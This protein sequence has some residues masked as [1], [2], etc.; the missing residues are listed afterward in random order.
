MLKLLGQQQYHGDKIYE[1][2]LDDEEMRLTN[3][4]FVTNW[5]VQYAV[6]PAKIA[7][8]RD[9]DELRELVVSNK[10]VRAM[11]AMHST[12]AL[13]CVDEG[14]EKSVIVNLKNLSNLLHIDHES[15]RIRCGAGMI[16]ETLNSVMFD[17]GMQLP[18][19]G[20]FDRQ[21]VGGLIMTGT[22]GGSSYHQAIHEN[23][24]WF[25]VMLADGTIKD[26]TREHDE[27]FA[28]FLPSIGVLG[29]VTALELQ[30]VRA[31]Y[32]EA[33]H[34]LLP[35]IADTEFPGGVPEAL[36][37]ASQEDLDS[38]LNNFKQGTERTSQS[39]YAV[40]GS[41]DATAISLFKR[42]QAENE[43][44]RWMAYTHINR[45]SVWV[46]NRVSVKPSQEL[47]PV[48]D[49]V[50]FRSDEEHK[51]LVRVLQLIE[52]EI[53]NEEKFPQIQQLMC[54]VVLQQDARLK[55]YVGRFHHI[56]CMERKNIVPHSD[57]EVAYDYA[58]T[59]A[60]L[61]LLAKDLQF[62]WGQLP[63][64]TH[65]ASMSETSEG[66]LLPRIPATLLDDYP[67][68]LFELRCCKQG[69]AYLSNAY[70]RDVLY[71]EFKACNKF[72]DTHNT[73]MLNIF[74]DFPCMFH[75]GKCISSNLWQRNLRNC[76]ALLDKFPEFLQL[77]ES[78]DPEGKFRNADVQ[79]WYQ[80]GRALCGER[81]SAFDRDSHTVRLCS[82]H[83]NRP[84][85]DNMEN[86]RW[87]STWAALSL[88]GISGMFL[89]SSP[90]VE[91][92][93]KA[94]PNNGNSFIAPGVLL[95]AVYVFVA[96][97]V[98]LPV[99]GHLLRAGTLS[100]GTLGAMTA[101]S[102]AYPLLIGIGADLSCLWLQF[103]GAAIGSLGY[104]SVMQILQVVAIQWWASID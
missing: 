39:N 3:K 49:Y 20:S 7:Y 56:L 88:S 68:Y 18:Q 29:I 76:I 58:D 85:M 46:A 44:V 16:L 71:F 28:Y 64:D 77:M 34:V 5:A 81:A 24:T 14:D 73:R 52:S 50:P 12:S 90:L 11:G 104:A 2:N 33:R 40:A 1:L 92:I 9:E 59:A 23:V 25:R 87:K 83:W 10:S 13:V 94:I 27:E 30:C 89:G 54:N 55:R 47:Q 82:E 67:F 42:I 43:Y 15:L 26:L 57:L 17:A 97:G 95:P 37:H 6:D 103:A 48:N 22:H 38:V 61:S 80:E 70:K 41:S 74:K 102:L 8:P 4:D 99:F 75:W 78:L 72:A 84:A 66:S 45:C 91:Y 36:G 32:V 98:L 60:I 101:F 93:N 21:T 79:R 62:R 96:L 51:M 31:T 63:S 35:I 53:S 100:V 69:A 86:M 65:F 19:L